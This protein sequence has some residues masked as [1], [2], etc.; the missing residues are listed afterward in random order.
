MKNFQG[1][2]EYSTD[3]FTHDYSRILMNNHY[4]NK[5]KK[6]CKMFINVLQM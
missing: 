3:P 6:N 4:L 1:I 2:Q 5:I